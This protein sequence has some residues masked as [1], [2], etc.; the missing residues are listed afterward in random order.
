MMVEPPLISK[1]PEF[2]IAGTEWK[3]SAIKW[4]RGY[5]YTYLCLKYIQSSHTD[6]TGKT[7]QRS[8]SVCG[9]DGLKWSGRRQRASRWAEPGAVRGDLI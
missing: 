4:H 8:A 7:T 5:S 1:M 2:S 6:C 9:H 3:R